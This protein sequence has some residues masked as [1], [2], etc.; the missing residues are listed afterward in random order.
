MHAVDTRPRELDRLR[1]DLDRAWPEL[2]RP[3][4]LRW[5]DDLVV[6]LHGGTPWC[7]GP[8]EKDPLRTRD[9]RSVVPRD[10]RARLR[11]WVQR[12]VPFQRIA[13]AH[14]LP[15]SAV[16]GRVLP[17][18]RHGPRTCTDQQARA[19]VEPV[20]APP[21]T[22]RA[23]AAMTRPRGVAGR[24]L[25]HLLDPIVLGVIAPGSP[26]HDELC[27]WYPLAVWRW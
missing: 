10:Q 16:V 25:E 6:A 4:E 27:L 3:V 23:V 26:R 8:A 7:Y 19:L 17:A 21:R 14:E 5:S 9:G 22:R 11:A 24:V 13:I 20:P 12:G 2:P 1:A 15:R 18:L